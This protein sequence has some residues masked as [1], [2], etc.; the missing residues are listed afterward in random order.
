MNLEEQYAAMIEEDD[1]DAVVV[2]IKFQPDEPLVQPKKRSK[3]CRIYQ[4]YRM[5]LINLLFRLCSKAARYLD[6]KRR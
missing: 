2:T 3:A 6:G 4:S 1:S 5:R